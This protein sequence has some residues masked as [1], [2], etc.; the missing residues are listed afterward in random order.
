MS[1]TRVIR[2]STTDE[3]PADRA[4]A[5]PARPAS[6]SGP[7]ARPA[8]RAVRPGRRPAATWR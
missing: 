5:S 7:A 4:A 8:H 6:P 2:G 3:R 1:D